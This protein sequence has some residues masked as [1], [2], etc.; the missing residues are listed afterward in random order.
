MLWQLQDSVRFGFAYIINE[1]PKSA[2][3]FSPDGEFAVEYNL[4]WKDPGLFAASIWSKPD[5]RVSQGILFGIQSTVQQI[6][7]V[8]F[9]G[10]FHNLPFHMLEDRHRVLE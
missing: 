1:V 8:I 3:R 4:W 9:S 7:N 6:A 10:L 5:H 2:L